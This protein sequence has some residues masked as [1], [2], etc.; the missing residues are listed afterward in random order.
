MD[1]KSMYVI[2]AD[3]GQIPGQLQF[4]YR[5]RYSSESGIIS[6]V[7][8]ELGNLVAATGFNRYADSISYSHTGFICCLAWA[9]VTKLTEETTADE[10]LQSYFMYFRDCEVLSHISFD[11]EMYQNQYDSD[12]ACFEYKYRKEGI[13]TDSRLETVAA[14]AKRI[15]W[16]YEIPKENRLYEHADFE[17]LYDRLRHQKILRELG[18]DEEL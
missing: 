1:G 17:G 7:I 14:L 6:D 2:S 11:S 16:Y 8:R 18:A 12:T 3:R 4:N 13:E 15:T 10:I 9:K 5:R